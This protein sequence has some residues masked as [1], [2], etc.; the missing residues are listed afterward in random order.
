MGKIEFRRG[1]TSQWTTSNPVLA[2]A[3]P[4]WDSTLKRLK[5]GDGSTSW[6]TLSF[7]GASLNGVAATRTTDGA[8]SV[9][10]H[11]PVD[12][13]SATRN[14][15]IPD[16]SSPGLLIGIEKTD[17]SAN[18]V[19]I[20]GK[21][22]GVT[23]ST[24]TITLHWSRQTI[25][26]L[27]NA[28]GTWWPIA[29][30]VTKTALDAAYAAFGSGGGGGSAPTIANIPPGSTITVQKD[31]VTGFWPASYASDG[32]P[33]YTGGS[34]SAGVRPS[35]RTDITVQWK[36]PDPDPAIVNSG[37]GGMLNNIDTRLTTP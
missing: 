3:E 13:T 34:T 29:G 5:L 21:F 25:L 4:G 23:G 17:A 6:S 32:T 14:V 36:G 18:T 9:L 31:I 12:A 7:F 28:D 15:S 22:R 19:V 35:A 11:N 26:F 16:A 33:V 20:T 2:S 10:L 24:S 30:H 37:T 8:V 1:T 27:S